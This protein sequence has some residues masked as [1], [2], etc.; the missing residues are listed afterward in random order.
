M[1]DRLKNIYYWASRNLSIVLSAVTFLF[2]VFMFV[3]ARHD[4]VIEEKTI[5][6]TDT[7]YRFKD[8]DRK[9]RFKSTPIVSKLSK[10]ESEFRKAARDSIAKYFPTNK[11]SDVFAREKGVDIIMEYIYSD[12]KPGF[13]MA[14][15]ALE[16]RYG[17]SKL[18]QKTGNLGNFKYTKRS[19]KGA[20]KTVKKIYGTEIEVGKI[21]GKDKIEKS[22][23]YY[24]DYPTDFAG[25]RDLT[26]KL[27]S[28]FDVNDY[29]ITSI[30][31]YANRLKSRGYATDKKYVSKMIGVFN[32]SDYARLNTIAWQLKRMFKGYSFYHISG[33]S[34]KI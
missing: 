17:Q 16:S 27:C 25:L 29:E 8:G 32:D 23:D 31:A 2:V 19:V 12:I 15:L 34:Q 18:C 33:K 7:I 5:F 14:H 1:K 13:Y 28:K 10:E 4:R 26:D 21:R 3:F 30:S 11:Q 9:D 6:K 22:N 20:K 24:I